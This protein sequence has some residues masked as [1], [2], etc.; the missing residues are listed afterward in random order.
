MLS[1]GKEVILEAE[2]PVAGGRML[3]RHDGQ[4]VLVAGAIPGERVRVRIDHVKG[5]VAFGT[6]GAIERA[7]PDRRPAGPDPACGGNVY[8][9][10]AYSRQLVLKREIVADAFSRIAHL[11]LAADARVHGSPERGYRMRARLH[12]QG[13]RIGFYR[14]ATHTLCDAGS[15]GQLHDVT[16]SVLGGLSRAIA[17]GAIGRATSVE[18]N[19]NVDATSRVI[20]VDLGDV[21]EGG[22]RHAI[23]D[24]ADVTGVAIARR[25]QV[26]ASRGGLTVSDTISL[27]DAT[28]TIARGPGGFFQG[29]RYLLTTLANQVLGKVPP[30][31]LVDLYAGCGLF[32]VA[33]AAAGRGRVRAVESDRASIRD[34]RA[35]ASPFGGAVVVEAATVERF[36]SERQKFGAPTVLVDPP[37]TG[38][39][40]EV[41]ARL[42]ASRI[43]CIVYLSCDVATLARDARRLV[44]GGFGLGEVEIFDLFPTTG[45]V[46]TLAVFGRSW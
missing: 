15:S 44:D 41:S 32:G 36:L 9:H 19:E 29:N 45:H 10:I 35:N 38:L 28:V 1:L 31:D 13:S 21:P 37:R 6:V 14:E 20:V 42:T 43:S 34:L 39:S 27:G 12:V 5:G 23:P 46:E 11:P 8:A 17:A 2:K 7:S 16:L 3:A 40:R 25:G 30:G 33:Y 26:V 4:V 18:I 22:R 24:V